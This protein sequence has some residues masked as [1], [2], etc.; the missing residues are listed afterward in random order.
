MENMIFIS[1]TKD[2]QTE[3][4]IKKNYAFAAHVNTP[5]LTYFL[6]ARILFKPPGSYFNS[7]NKTKYVAS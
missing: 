3:N 7:D 6:M 2:C 4:A 1:K 5:Y